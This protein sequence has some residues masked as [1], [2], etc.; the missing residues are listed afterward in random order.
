MKK[1]C[2]ALVILF[3]CN[4]SFA[5]LQVIPQLFSQKYITNAVYS[6]SQKIVASSEYRVDRVEFMDARTKLK[7]GA[8]IT[9]GPVISLAVDSSGKYFVA[10]TERGVIHIIDAGSLTIIKTIDAGIKAGNYFVILNYFPLLFAD[11]T[12][13]YFTGYVPEPTSKAGKTAITDYYIYKYNLVSNALTRIG[14]SASNKPYYFLWNKKQKTI[15]VMGEKNLI[16]INLATGKEEPSFSTSALQLSSF[17]SENFFLDESENNRLGILSNESHNLFFYD[18]RTFKK[19]DSLKNV[20]RFLKTGTDQLLYQSMDKIFYTIQLKSK[21]IKLVTTDS[22]ENPQWCYSL[23]NFQQNVYGAITRNGIGSINL[24]VSA[25]SMPGYAD[26]PLPWG[27][28]VTGAS[29]LV[30]ATDKTLYEFDFMQANLKREVATFS[31]MV[32]KSLFIPQ[33]QLLIVE[34]FQQNAYGN[35]VIDSL[36]AL[37]Y[38]TGKILWKYNAGATA[39][40]GISMSSDS[41]RILLLIGRNKLVELDISTGQVLE[42]ILTPK[43]VYGADFRGEV[44]GFYTGLTQSNTGYCLEGIGKNISQFSYGCFDYHRPVRVFATDK[45]KNYAAIAYPEDSHFY[46]FPLHKDSSYTEIS[47]N[48][49]VILFSQDNQWLATGSFNGGYVRLYRFPSLDM[50][51]DIKCGVG[52]VFDLVFSA[53]SKLLFAMLEDGYVSVIN[54][55]QKKVMT[56]MILYKNNFLVKD[57]LGYYTANKK[58]VNEIGLRVGNRCYPISNAD[59]KFNRPD[60]IIR[61]MGVQ[62]TALLAAY[63]KAYEKRLRR[64]KTDSKQLAAI[65]SFPEAV[66]VNVQYISPKTKSTEIKLPVSFR[67]TT[68]PLKT[69]NVW[70]NDVP[71]FGTSGISIAGRKLQKLDTVLVLKLTGGDNSIEAECTDQAGV[72]STREQVKINSQA[73]S[74]FKTY[75]VG[76]G[77]DQFSQPTYNLSW[78]VKDIRDLAKNLQRK[79]PDLIIDTLLN[80]KV[81]TGNVTILKNRL[82]KTGVNDKVIIAY[83]GHG[84]LNKDFDYFLSTYSVNFDNPEDNG[85]PYEQLENLMDSIPARMKLLLIDACHSGEVDKEDLVTLEQTPDSL[86]KGLKPVAYKKAGQVG[87]KNSFE[88]MQGLFVNTGRSTG[89]TII[90]A[91]TGTQFALERND[92]KNGVFTYSILDAMKKY[93]TMKISELKKIVGEKVLQLTKGLQQPTSRNETIAMDWDIW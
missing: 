27:V 23:L 44:N 25:I 4:L 89:T 46:I 70:I 50:Y 45:T 68:T 84:L 48:A 62:D 7:M 76:I 54:I 64:M 91:A 28:S 16:T 71:V 49:R 72:K 83:S 81:T 1:C 90:S 42:E 36:V 69:Y 80:E 59:I 22:L 57:S 18:T 73:P 20:Y 35:T 63:N 8:V 14:Q 39:I 26:D 58:Q 31:S 15:A 82:L 78:S 37:Q 74:A 2:L 55:A 9:Q 32:K 33:Q 19:V 43:T 13:F 53:D 52:K 40:T 67:S 17:G 60:M 93:P 12:T 51:C 41:L 30:Y 10:G 11:S 56:E 75:F 66:I 61:A 77:I 86:I 21:K 79:I 87:L 34:I 5:Q 29:T 88:L 47:T 24:N 38:Q 85:L 92:L 65:T 6:Y 3:T